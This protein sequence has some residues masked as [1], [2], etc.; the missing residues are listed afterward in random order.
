M[1]KSRLC[2][3][4]DAHILV[5]GIITI[6]NTGAAASLNNIK[7]MIIKNWSPLTDCINEINNAQTDNAEGIDVVISMYN[8][9]EYSNNYSKK[10]RKLWQ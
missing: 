2:Y 10:S 7:N 1:L 9:K 5:S 6:P 4:S 3:D 8:L